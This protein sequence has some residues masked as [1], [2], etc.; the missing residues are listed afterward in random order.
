MRIR[1]SAGTDLPGGY[2]STPT[3]DHPIISAAEI[4][5]MLVTAHDLDSEYA[6]HVRTI[7]SKIIQSR[8]TGRSISHFALIGFDCPLELSVLGANLGV[9]MARLGT[10]TL[11]VDAARSDAR[12]HDLLGV[13]NDVGVSNLNAE[14]SLAEIAHPTVL[15]Q[16]W[17]VPAGPELE[18][19]GQVVEKEALISRLNRWNIPSSTILASVPIDERTN[20]SAVADMVAGMDGV[21]LFLRRHATKIAEVRA[22]VDRLDERAVP[23]IG[24]VVV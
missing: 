6:Q 22:L 4:H 8:A 23:V 5:P 21:V 9:V 12:I 7:R 13:S 17:L 16:L 15:D 19:G 14:V 1:S 18:D 11:L 2:A 20:Q 24:S 3:E 10:P